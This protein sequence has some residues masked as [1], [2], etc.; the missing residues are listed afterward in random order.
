MFLL[1]KAEKTTRHTG[2]SSPIENM[3]KKIARKNL[4]LASLKVDGAEIKLLGTAHVS[5]Q[6]VLDVENAFS[7]FKPDAVCVE[8]CDSRHDNIQ[9]PD[10]WKNLDLTKVIREG[11]LGLLVSSLILS[12]FQK[13]IGE[14]T[15]SPPGAEMIR[16]TQLAKKNKKELI[17]ADRDIRTTLSRAWRPIGFFSKTWLASQLAAS[18]LVR[19]EVNEEEIEKMKQEDVLSDLFKSL[20]KRYSSIKSVLID[21]RDEY[22]AQKIKDSI[23]LLKK[24][25]KAKP[26]ILA[27][28]GAGHLEGIQ[29]HLSS[30]KS[31]DL[32]NLEIVPPKSWLPTILTF[33]VFV[34]IGV[35]MGVMI[36]TGRG[37]AAAS[38][39][40]TYLL[41][42]SIGAG[43]GAI[44]AAAHP[45]TIV[46]AII[47]APVVPFI[48]GSRLWMLVGPIELWVRKPRVEDFETI[49]METETFKGLLYGLYNNRVLKLIW[50]V[51]L[52]QV[53]LFIGNANFGIVF[54]IEVIARF[55]KG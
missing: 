33:G 16:A 36:F 27:V 2:G 23:L 25:K 45:L 7:E 32:K 46:A 37:D 15:G 54:V 35:L 34:L 26:K 17:M 52:I 48:P 22:M 44:L 8:L 43:L 9:D 41:S 19:E 13:K 5:K 42:R 12:S 20:P 4:P 29:K 49:A 38:L 30:K 14:T 11:K 39:G 50:I 6:S 51:L 31:I 21:E 24:K 1:F 47:L 53:G 40:V 10:R 55:F 18:L 28:V 3:P